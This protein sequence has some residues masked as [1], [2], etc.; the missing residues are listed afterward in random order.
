MSQGNFGLDISFGCM[1]TNGK[2][3]FCFLGFLGSWFL[4]FGFWMSDGWIMVI[5]CW[6]R[7]GGCVDI[8]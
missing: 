8:G 7:M 4:V 5:S 3:L 6:E 1:K 2:K